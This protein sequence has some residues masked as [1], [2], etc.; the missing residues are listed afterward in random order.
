[1]RKD[2]RSAGTLADIKE[3]VK[4]ELDIRDDLNASSDMISRIEWMKKQLFDMKD[5]VSAGAGSR[6]MLKTFDELG[7]K[8]QSIEDELFQPTIAEGDTKS[9]RDP[10][11]LYEKFSVLAGDI[12]GSVDFAPNQQQREV[13]AA[14]KERLA[15][16]K[17]RFEGLLKTDLAAF[18]DLLKKNDIAGVIVPRLR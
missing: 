4:L 8:L 9:F 18:N 10:Q 1:V 15:A 2:P 13:Y 3:Q 12:A 5:V 6:D 16:Q 17:G 14:L 11:K 7:A